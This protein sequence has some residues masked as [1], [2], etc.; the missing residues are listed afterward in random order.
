MRA[1]V[2]SVNG[3]QL[4]TA[5]IGAEGV[6]SSHVTWSGREGSS[7]FHMHVGGLETASNQ[8]LN[9]PVTVIGVGDEIVT[10][11]IETQT[12]DDPLSRRTRAE[13][14]SEHKKSEEDQSGCST[15]L[16]ML[17]LF[18]RQTGS[19]THRGSNC[20][21]A[22]P[23]IGEWLAIDL[24]GIGVMARIVMVAHSNDSSASAAVTLY[25]VV[26][27]ATNDCLTKLVQA[28]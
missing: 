26:E 2:V 19:W 10:R 3:K 1:F 13:I 12:V 6:L 8:H 28:Q 14:E 25:A 16:T 4:C 7:N 11:I 27:G 20:F 9:W 22:L 17:N 18:D 21:A 24:D 15:V 5:G 23:R